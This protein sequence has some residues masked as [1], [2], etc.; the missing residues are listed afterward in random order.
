M[1]HD[2]NLLWGFVENNVV[3]G[4]NSWDNIYVYHGMAKYLLLN[5]GGEGFNNY[6]NWDVIYLYLGNTYII[7]YI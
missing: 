3:E 4:I 2:P 1:K 6:K 5:D 7:K